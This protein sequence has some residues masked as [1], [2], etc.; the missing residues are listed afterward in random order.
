MAQAAMSYGGDFSWRST[1]VK[2][3]ANC[4]ASDW[5][6]NSRSGSQITGCGSA[7]SNS[8]WDSDHLVGA[9]VHTINGRKVGYRSDQSC[10]PARG[11]KYL[12]CWYVGGKTKGNPVITVSVISYGSGGMD[13]AVD[14]YYL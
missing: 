14:W 4:A 6:N 12:K 1:E 8:Y 13:T 9:S 11:F 10:P 5:S 3:L 7:G 2:R